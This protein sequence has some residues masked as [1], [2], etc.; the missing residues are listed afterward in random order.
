MIIF[1]EE[2]NLEVHGVWVFRG[3]EIP[4]GMKECDDSEHYEWTRADINDAAQKKKLEDYFAWDGEFQGK[5]FLSGK[6][7]K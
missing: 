2:P 5:K 6:V 4:E 1:G 3:S 7:F